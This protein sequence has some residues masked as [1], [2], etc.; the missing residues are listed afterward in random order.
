MG[1][2]KNIGP[3]K[4]RIVYNANQSHE[5]RKQKTET[6][7]DVTSKQA[8][9]ILAER[10][11]VVAKGDFSKDEITIN[12][13]AEKF[14][15]ERT[16]RVN[17]GSFSA[18]TLQEE[19]L[20]FKGY[21]AP[22]F[23][24]IKIRDLKKHHIIQTLNQWMQR[25]P[26]GHKIS[27]QTVL[28]VKN[29]LRTMLSWAVE[30][31]LAS[32]NIVKELPSH[33]LPKAKKPRITVLDE[34]ELRKLLREAQYPTRQAK[35]RG[36]LSSQPWFYPAIAFAAYTGARRGEVLGLQWEDIDFTAKVATINRSLDE[37]RKLTPTKNRQA[38]SITLPDKLV[39]VLRS[40]RA[41]Q[42]EEKFALGK[43]YKDSGFVFAHADGSSIKPANFGAAFSNL[44]YRCDI[45][46]IKFHDLRH[47]HASLLG[48]SGTPIE[49]VSKR[50]GHS[51]IG[52]TMDYY[53]HIYQSEDKKAAEG[54]D[55]LMTG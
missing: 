50:L 16:L 20:K 24:P 27:E 29:L 44:V 22:V 15:A 46:R 19:S 3:K 40:H 54:F 9:V 13:L 48:K 52:V 25:S 35:R 4:Y 32:K 8:K 1:Y 6:L 10:E 34:T 51:N 53:L 38:L 33:D 36:Y 2:L 55:K 18:K 7:R 23:G 47:T 43:E 45:T 11:K 5:P 28:H 31:D 21:L 30:R 17:N 12:E 14:F 26:Y 37:N 49:V 39:Q 42:A 41:K